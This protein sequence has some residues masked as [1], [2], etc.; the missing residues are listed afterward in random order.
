MILPITIEQQSAFHSTAVAEQMAQGL[1][2]GIALCLLLYSLGQWVGSREPLFLKYALLV[3]GSMLFT[4]LLLG[5]GSQYVWTN[6]FWMEQHMS[7]ISSAMAIGG[8]FL[9]LEESLREPGRGLW[10]PRIMKGGAVLALLLGLVYAF[11]L[12]DTG[13]LSIIITLF[14]PIPAIICMPRFIER[15]RRG[16]AVGIYLLLAWTAY[17]LAVVVISAV[18]RGYEPVNFWTLHS[19]QFSATFDM[20]AFMYVLTLRTKAVRE[21]A[22]HASMERDIMR[23]LAHTD[24]LTGLPNRRS[25]SDALTQALLGASQDRM[26]A[27]YLIDVDEFK[28]VNDHHGH[29]V[30]DE[31]LVIISQRLQ[32][33]VRSGD[34]VARLGGDEFVVLAN[35][36]RSAAQASDLGNQLLKLFDAPVK[37]KHH[38]VRIGLTIGYAMAPLDGNEASV[39]LK[40]AD[41]AMYVG[42]QAG[43]RCLRRH[44][45]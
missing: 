9:F 28:P 16:E 26:L 2:V 36:L 24:P 35:G 12:I 37:L 31:L 30:G 44:E 40:L 6:N 45:A 41:A 23:A 42:K 32:A 25:L 38:E 3:S 20:L 18:I 19:F 27:V 10:F 33:N 43:K 8:T 5:V 21:A 1:M 34:I 11:D 13:V 29:D 7:G 14:G 17:M 15:V 22:V 39:I 4:L